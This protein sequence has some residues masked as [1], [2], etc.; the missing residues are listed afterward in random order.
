LKGQQRPEWQA[1]NGRAERKRVLARRD[2]CWRFSAA[3]AAGGAAWLFWRRSGRDTETFV[4]LAPGSST[5]RIGQQLEAA[6]VVRSRFAF[7][8]LRFWKR[9]TLRA[10]EY[11]FDHPASGD[12]SLCAD[13]ARGC[14]YQDGDHSGGLKHL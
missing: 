13:R 7:D 8:L 10:G 5:A 6:G 12:R 1:A 9:G 11:R 2:S 3:L 14:F 4:E